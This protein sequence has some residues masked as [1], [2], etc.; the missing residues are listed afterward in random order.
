[1]DF[2][3]E[4]PL[5]GGFNGLYNF[6]DQLTKFVKLVPVLIGEEPY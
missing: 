5:C 3:T 2:I 6:V 1:M 4:L